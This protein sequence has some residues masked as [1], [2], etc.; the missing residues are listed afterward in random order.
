LQQQ[1]AAGRQQ[2]DSRQAAAIGSNAD[3]GIALIAEAAAATMVPAEAVKAT[4]ILPFL[5]T[6]C[7]WA[8][9]ERSKCMDRSHLT[10]RLAIW[11]DH[12]NF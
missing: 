1:Q 9:E 5:E 4:Y 8:K 6:G 2:P 12:G 7:Q 11:G 3:T 10:L